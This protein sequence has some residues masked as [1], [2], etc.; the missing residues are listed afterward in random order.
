VEGNVEGN[1]KGNAEGIME[2][3]MNTLEIKNITKSYKRFKLDDVSFTVPEGSICGFVGINGAGKS[4]TV[5]IVEGL[6]GKESGTVTFWGEETLSSKVKEE[7]GFVPDSCYFYEKQSIKKLKRFISGLYTNWDEETYRK[8]IDFFGL[9]EKKKIGELSKGMRMQVSL[10]FALSHNS[11][12]L[13]M[14]EPTSGLD[15]YIRSKMMAILR[16]FVKDGKNSVL[17]STHILSDLDKTAD[18]IVF[19]HG[20]KIIFEANK[21][22]LPDLFE[23]KLGME[24]K[25]LDENIVEYIEILKGEREKK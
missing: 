1:A 3:V 15:P 14:D 24:W 12:L 13:I 7:I 25:S 4:T 16:D 6:V 22:E 19:I 23:N 18:K 8:Y 11:R 5:K 20:G 9:D 10:V 21:E 2:V 17:F